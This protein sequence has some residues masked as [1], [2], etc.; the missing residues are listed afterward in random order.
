MIASKF[1]NLFREL[2]RRHVFRVAGAYAVIA[3]LTVEVADILT[4]AFNSPDWIIQGFIAVMALGFPIAIVVAWAFELT[5]MGILRDSDAQK[6]EKPHASKTVHDS[7]IIVLPL[8]HFGK[9]DSD[10]YI[11]EGM[12]EDLITLLSRTPGLFVIARNTSDTYKGRNLPIREVVKEL[13]VRY[14]VEGSLRR[15]G[16]QMRVNIQLIEGASEEHIWAQRFDFDE[17]DLFDVKHDIYVRISTQLSGSV[18]EAESKRAKLMP[19]HELDSWLLTQRAI[20]EYYSGA[21]QDTYESAVKLIEKA[22]EL[23]P[24]YAYALA[25]HAHLCTTGLLLG[26]NDDEETCSRIA[27]EQ[28]QHALKLAPN[29]P[30]VLW[31][32][33]V[34]QGF[35]GN[36]AGAIVTLERAKESNP[37]D[38]HILADLGHFLIQVG[39][40]DEGMEFLMLAFQH[41]PHEP[42]AYVWHFYLGTGLSIH[43][44]EA[45]LAEFEKS[46]A[47]FNAYIPSLSAKFVALA[48]L[49]R[50]EDAQIAANQLFEIH[51]KL[52]AGQLRRMYEMSIDNP[53]ALAQYTA[54][55]DRYAP[56][57]RR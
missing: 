40:V 29:D 7:S 4:D 42:R 38:P 43:D 31:C 13:G 15:M 50:D 10:D 19:S 23:D 9:S 22:L 56:A 48:V 14:V 45:G 26:F 17:A 16:D 52:T 5:P 1:N 24:E 44:R 12:T 6:I 51:P 2:H 54:I 3:W 21:A 33:G 27:D 28:I 55:I 39:R 11:A 35:F 46:I 30:M 47:L 20:H 41:S 57:D 36:K 37:N 34:V 32:W 53:K 8:D 25:M 18:I 49:E